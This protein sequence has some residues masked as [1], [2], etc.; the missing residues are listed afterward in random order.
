MLWSGQSELEELNKEIAAAQVVRGFVECHLD[1]V[2]FFKLSGPTRAW[3]LYQF[4][5]FYLYLLENE[6]KVGVVKGNCEAKNS[7]DML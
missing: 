4:L 5:T 3:S 2:N 6:L 1:L 7:F